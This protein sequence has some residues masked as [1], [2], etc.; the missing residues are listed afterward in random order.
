MS[1]PNYDAVIVGAGII[2]AIV[3]KQLTKEGK[4]VLILEAGRAMALDYDD[5]RSFEAYRSYVDYYQTQLIKIPNS[6]Y[7]PNPSAPSPYATDNGATS[8][9]TPDLKGYWVQDGKVPFMSSY[10]RQ[11]G[12]TTLHWMGSAMRSLPNDFRM[13]TLYG[14]GR[15]W[16]LGYDDIKPYY[17]LAEWEIGVSANKDEQSYY[18]ITFEEGYDYPMKGL[19]P[20]WVDQVV[21]EKTRGLKVPIGTDE[22][23]IVVGGLPCARNSIPRRFPHA[24]AKPGEIPPW[25]GYMPRGAVG[26]PH[27]GQRCEGNSSCTPICPV[28]AKYNALKTLALLPKNLCTIEAQAVA[29]TVTLGEDG[30]VV[31]LNYKSYDPEGGAVTEKS[32][33]ARIFVLAAHAVENAKIVLASRMAGQKVVPSTDQVGRNL[34]DHPYFMTWGLAPMDLGAFRGPGYTSGIPVFRD[35]SFREHSAAFRLDMGNWGWNF[36]AGAPFTDVTTLVGKKVVGTRLRETLGQTVPRQFRFG[37]QIEQLPSDANRVSVSD[38]YKDAIGNYRPVITYDVDDYTYRAMLHGIRISTAIFERM[39]VPPDQRFHLEAAYLPTFRELD[40]VGLA[41]F[42]AGHLAGS[43]RM[44][45]RGDGSVV[46]V[47]QCCHDHDNLYMVGCGSFPTI[48]TANPTLTAA[49][50]AYKAAEAMIQRLA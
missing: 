25:D 33:R 45:N 12:G 5:Y 48:A 29:T 6:P 23:E 26:A 17:R 4:R 41:F 34:M 32:V 11:M 21:S 40:G 22:K 44:G 24:T 35:G 7:P 8:S 19:P 1:E 3:A 49:A 37:F 31:L 39:G 20:S 18:G 30:R 28:Q 16:P 14:Q 46:D 2:G 36:S 43:H 47:N 38:T 9:E 15:D 42:G 10:L 27:I 50:L 13:R